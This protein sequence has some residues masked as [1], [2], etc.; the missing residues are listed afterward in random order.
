MPSGHIFKRSQDKRP[1]HTERK[2]YEKRF[3][4]FDIKLIYYVIMFLVETRTSFIMKDTPWLSSMLFAEETVTLHIVTPSKSGREL[5]KK[6]LQLNEF[7]QRNYTEKI[8]AEKSPVRGLL[9]AVVLFI[10]K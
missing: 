8:Q 2:D 4:T 6:T 7:Y 1:Q 9:L 10:T 5:W 3:K